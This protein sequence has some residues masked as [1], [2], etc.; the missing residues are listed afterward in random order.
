M[1]RDGLHPEVAAALHALRRYA[2]LA[3]IRL[4]QVDPAARTF[5]DRL[6]DIE[7]EGGMR[8][9][10]IPSGRDDLIGLSDDISKLVK[11]KPETVAELAAHELHRY[12]PRR[13]R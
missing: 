8:T 1:N 13:P 12:L 3:S 11:A 4:M 9:V 5:L 6:R 7:I 2:Y 10:V